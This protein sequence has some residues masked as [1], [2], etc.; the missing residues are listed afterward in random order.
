MFAK[1]QTINMELKSE[2]FTET[3]TVFYLE[4]GTVVYEP[5]YKSLDP[6][7]RIPE[8]FNIF[9]YSGA[10]PIQLYRNQ[11]VKLTRLLPVAYQAFKQGDTSFS[12]EVVK[13]KSQLITLEVSD[14]KDKTYLFLKKRF[15]PPETVDDPNQ[16]WIHT[17]SNVSFHPDV[18]DA[19]RLIK[20]VLNCRV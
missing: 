10:R 18:D 14:Y 16:E 20:F 1:F 13:N 12:A 2:E 9:N 4:Y 8:H 7:E 6:E 17:K 3:S 11:M 5:E 15:K 19:S